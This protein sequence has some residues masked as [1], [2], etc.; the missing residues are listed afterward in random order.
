MHRVEIFSMRNISEQKDAL[1]ERAWMHVLASANDSFPPADRESRAAQGAAWP[2]ERR[3]ESPGDGWRRTHRFARSS[4]PAPP[5]PLFGGLWPAGGRFSHSSVR[6]GPTFRRAG[7]PLIATP[8]GHHR[9]GGDD[10][11]QR[12]T[13]VQFERRH[14]ALPTIYFPRVPPFPPYPRAIYPTFTMAPKN[15]GKGKADNSASDSKDGG[16]KGGGGKLKAAT[17]INVRHI[18][19]EKHSRKEEA[20]GKLREGKK[21]DEVAREFSEDKARQGECFFFSFCSSGGGEEGG[22]RVYRD[23]VVSSLLRRLEDF[24]GR[25]FGYCKWL[26]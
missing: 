5:P 10:D 1:V 17:S 18:L 16:G 26:S 15:K 24:E 6:L 9:R 23:Y 2:W 20:L 21:F 14:T 8:V 12:R 3:D 22:G 4:L 13:C 25:K 11:I 19:C 7:I